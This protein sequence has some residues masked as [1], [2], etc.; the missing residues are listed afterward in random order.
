MPATVSLG[1]AVLLGLGP[2]EARAQSC[3]PE[4]CQPA[5]GSAY[6]STAH[7][8]HAGIGV[9]V[10][11]GNPNLHSF[12]TCTSLPASVPGATATHAFDA[13][14]DCTISVNGGA[15]VPAT[16][17]AHV[18]TLDR[19][20][21]TSGP[22]RFFDTEMLQLDISGLPGGM[23]LRESPTIASPGQTTV[24][25]L[26]GGNFRIDS[27]FDV[28]T[29]LSIDGGATW[30]PCSTCPGHTTLIGQGCPT[31]SRSGSWGHVKVI[32]R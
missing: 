12:T 15:S 9:T 22:T 21:H 14:V 5:P 11:V 19:Y 16:A 8:V 6:A 28:F 23:L 2:R 25:D 7:F 27:F 18:T 1:A 17:P 32:Y 4:D 20:N 29:E 10:D 26:G 31:P 13:V 3:V 24:Q 30:I